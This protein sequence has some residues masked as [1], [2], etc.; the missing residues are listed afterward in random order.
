MGTMGNIILVLVLALIVF[1]PE[2]LPKIARNLGK[3]FSQIRKLT[4]GVTKDFNSMLQDP[5]DEIKKEVTGLNMD[6]DVD[7]D[8]DN[9]LRYED[10]TKDP[11]ES[12][13]GRN[14]SR[15]A[16]KAANPLEALPREL[17]RDKREGEDG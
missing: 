4:Q 2:E 6:V 5:V 9:L 10:L 3:A 16:P 13:Q 15:S 7:L 12:A 11:K 17:V 8:L 14:A 1:G